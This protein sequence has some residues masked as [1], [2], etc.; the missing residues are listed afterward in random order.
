MSVFR[1]IGNSSVF[2]KHFDEGRASRFRAW[3]SDI[4]Q[5]PRLRGQG[6]QG[7]M[8]QASCEQQGGDNPKYSQQRR[9][10]THLNNIKRV[11]GEKNMDG[12]KEKGGK[13]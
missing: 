11:K 8:D 9:G 13:A 6:R 5:D 2:L 10:F 1:S 4:G 3:W 12:G 7:I